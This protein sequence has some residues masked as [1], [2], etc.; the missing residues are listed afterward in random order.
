GRGSTDNSSF[1]IS[2]NQIL[3]ADAFSVPGKTYSVRFR[4]T[5]ENGQTIEQ[6]DTITVTNDP[7]L[8]LSGSTL[9]INGTAVSGA[10]SFSFTPGAVQD[11]MSFSGDALG[12]AL[13][14]DVSTVSAVV[15]QG[16]G[17]GASAN[18]FAAS[19]G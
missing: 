9:T 19:S 8:T 13:A 14:A 18:L 7:A 12:S 1:T 5:D 16:N 10:S 3:T 17:S 11:S 6:S 4:S 15:F 2:G